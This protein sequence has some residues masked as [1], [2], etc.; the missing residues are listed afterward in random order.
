MS[1]MA[2]MH[3]YLVLVEMD[4]NPRT[5]VWTGLLHR[6]WEPADTNRIAA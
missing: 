2:V 3:S 1:E 6:N 4:S 5:G